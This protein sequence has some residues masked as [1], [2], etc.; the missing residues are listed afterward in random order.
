[1]RKLTSIP[2]TIYGLVGRG[3][4]AEGYAADLLLFDPARVG[5]SRPRRVGDLPGGHM[6]MTRD[7]NGVAGVWINGTRIVADDV[8][9]PV[10]RPPGSV[11]R[12]F[13]A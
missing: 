12:R 13:A 2:A 6:R 5:S 8:V 7:P 1:V 3:R 9:I 11:L 4:I 10:V